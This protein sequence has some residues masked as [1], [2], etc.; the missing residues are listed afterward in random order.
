MP[1]SGAS[2][3]YC[4]WVRPRGASAR[5]IAAR[6]RMDSRQIRNPTLPRT[7]VSVLV[8]SFSVHGNLIL[9]MFIMSMLTIRES[10][11]AALEA[12]SGNERHKDRRPAC[13]GTSRAGQP[14]GV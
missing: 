9:D 3:A 1:Y 7:S 12:H 10:H 14:P 13:R 8:T 11:L 5:S 6:Q 2:T 4:A